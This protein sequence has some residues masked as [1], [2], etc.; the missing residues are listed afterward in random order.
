MHVFHVVLVLLAG[1]NA[2]VSV[3]RHV[4]SSLMTT[5]EAEGLGCL[6]LGNVGPFLHHEHK[7]SSLDV[8]EISE[9]RFPSL[10]SESRSH[11]A[12]F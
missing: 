8:D 1:S 5:H 11:P 4:A 6:R 12:I 2:A 7:I 9:Y 10:L 3:V